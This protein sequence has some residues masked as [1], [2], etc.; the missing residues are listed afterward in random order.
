MRVRTEISSAFLSDTTHYNRPWPLLIH[1]HSQEGIT[2]VIA[3]ANIKTGSMLLYERVLK[4]QCFDFV[5]N[6]YPLKR[7]CGRDHGRCSRVQ[8][9][10]IL[11]IVSH[12]RSQV[13]C[14]ANVND[15]AK[16]ISELIRPWRRWY[17]ARSWSFNRHDYFFAGVLRFAAVVG[18]GA[19]FF[20][21]GFVA[22]AFF[23]VV[24]FTTVFCAVS[25]GMDFKP[26][27]GAK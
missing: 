8:L 23:S 24:F 17:R 6:F 18:L 3:Q 22:A 9:G 10:H 16:F 27:I 2:L 1:R 25:I 15:S 19:V 5:T 13:R 4:N 14:F 7:M 20:A 21:A 11:K 26:N 12:S